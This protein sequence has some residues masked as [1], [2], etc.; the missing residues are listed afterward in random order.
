M[1]LEGINARKAAAG[2]G[3]R[4]GLEEGE[5]EVWDGDVE[6]RGIREVTENSVALF[7]LS[8]P[9]KGVWKA[10]KVGEAA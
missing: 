2:A 10:D 7:L 8:Y 6:E 9:G 4:R 1:A 3:A 5:Q